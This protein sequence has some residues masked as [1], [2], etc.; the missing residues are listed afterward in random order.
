VEEISTHTP[1]QTVDEYICKTKNEG[2]R[3]LFKRL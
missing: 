3:N 2:R 1:Q